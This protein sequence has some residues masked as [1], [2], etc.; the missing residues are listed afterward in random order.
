MLASIFG[1]P[2]VAQDNSA[3][4]SP[5]Q[6]LSEAAD[7][8]ATAKSR[9]ASGNFAG[10]LSAA[11]QA[12]RIL[13]DLTAKIPHNTEAQ[14]YLTLTYQTLGDIHQAQ[15]D[16]DDAFHFYSAGLGVAKDRQYLFDLMWTRDA[17]V[18]CGRLGDVE[19]R[20]GD[21]TR[22]LQYYRSSLFF[23]EES[24]KRATSDLLGE[25]DVAMAYMKLASA[26]TAVGDHEEALAALRRGQSIMERLTNLQPG[27][28]DWKKESDWFNKQ[29]AQLKR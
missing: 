22:A 16:L 25:H 1:Q 23:L 2:T 10:A 28:A 9:L 11:G 5:E 21:L 3:R 13:L 7:F 15:G 6:Q 19:T 18:L 24:T 20:Q 14:R 29:I 27:N 4:L 17:G 12:R 26:Y 8:I